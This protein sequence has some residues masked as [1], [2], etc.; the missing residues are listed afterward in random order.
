[1]IKKATTPIACAGGATVREAARLVAIA[2]A[3]LGYNPATIGRKFDTLGLYF[4]GVDIK[5][6]VLRQPTLLLRDLEGS[7]PSKA[8]LLTRLLPDANVAAMIERQ[9]ASHRR[10]RSTT[11]VASR[12]S[13]FG[14]RKS[15]ASLALGTRALSG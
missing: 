6:M 10:R 9:P 7:V 1:M 12:K 13:D 4:I 14:S 2:P 11:L 3:L 5:R 8:R 15:G